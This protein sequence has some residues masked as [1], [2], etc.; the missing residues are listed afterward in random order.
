MTDH[1][2]SKAKENFGLIPC[3]YPSDETLQDV[4]SKTPWQRFEHYVKTLNGN[5]EEGTEYK[6]LYLGRHGQGYHNVAESRYGTKLWDV[7]TYPFQP[8]LSDPFFSLRFSL[9]IT[10]GRGI[11]LIWCHKT[12][13]L[14][15]SRR[16]RTRKLVRRPSHPHRRTT[17]PR[18]RHI[19]AHRPRRRKSPRPRNL[20]HFPLLPLLANRKPILFLP[21]LTRRST[22]C[23]RG[24]G[25]VEGDQWRAHL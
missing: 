19:L 9:S 1:W 13:L 3:A 5:A 25:I 11:M 14:G 12:G 10:R 23:S 16:R 8:Y 24:Q 20:L 22:F 21:R 15:P 17:S 6:V 7:S 2:H 18:R 4:E